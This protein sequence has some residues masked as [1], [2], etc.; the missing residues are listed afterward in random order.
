MYG[1]KLAELLTWMP[2]MGLGPLAVARLRSPV[3]INHIQNKS[4][5]VPEMGECGD[6]KHGPQRGELLCPF[7]GELGLHLIQCGLDRAGLSYRTLSARSSS[8][9]RHLRCTLPSVSRFAIVRCTPS[10]DR[11]A[12]RSMTPTMLRGRHFKVPRESQQSCPSGTAVARSLPLKVTA[13]CEVHLHIVAGRAPARKGVRT[14]IP[15]PVIPTSAIP[16]P[17]ILVEWVS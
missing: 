9:C 11:R 3:C 6:N 14:T 1:T 7:R 12:R 4:S 13:A 2:R 5:I 15:T 16:T 8:T 10:R 17:A